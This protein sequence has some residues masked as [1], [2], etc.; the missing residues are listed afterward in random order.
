[1]R[2][3]EG[4]AL[5]SHMWLT[6]S[7]FHRIGTVSSDLRATAQLRCKWLHMPFVKSFFANRLLVRFSGGLSGPAWSS[8]KTGRS[9]YSTRNAHEGSQLFSLNVADNRH[10]AAAEK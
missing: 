10:G 9:L 1:M 8:V 5:I 7:S 6:Q 3:L 4:E 2:L